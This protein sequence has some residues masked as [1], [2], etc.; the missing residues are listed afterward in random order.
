[1]QCRS[2]WCIVH[3]LDN[4]SAGV[5][6]ADPR[7]LCGEG[8]DYEGCLTDEQLERSVYCTCRCDG[9]KTSVE[10]CQCPSGFTCTEIF[11]TS[12]APGAGI[13]G[14]YCVKPR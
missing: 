10:F 12:I 3:K 2:R 4:D 5:F 9:P 6:P 8:S 11:S 14:S 7:E 13:A 1:M